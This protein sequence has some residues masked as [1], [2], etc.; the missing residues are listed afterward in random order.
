M[1]LCVQMLIP[2]I[3]LFLSL[4]CSVFHG[5][6]PGH[7]NG[8]GIVDSSGKLHFVF[9]NYFRDNIIHIERDGNRWKQEDVVSLSG[10]GINSEMFNLDGFLCVDTDS[11]SGL[12]R[13]CL[14]AD[15]TWKV[16]RE[17]TV[18]ID[19]YPYCHWSSIG[20]PNDI[21]PDGKTIAGCTQTLQ[22][23]LPVYDFFLIDN[24]A[25]E[26]LPHF[27][28]LDMQVFDSMSS[29]PVNYARQPW[30]RE[31]PF[32]NNEQWDAASYIV[33]VAYWD[34][35]DESTG[36]TYLYYVYFD[37]TGWHFE[38]IHER[39]DNWLL[40]S[41]PGQIWGYGLETIVFQGKKVTMVSR[42][43]I[44][45]KDT[46]TGKV[47]VEPLDEKYIATYKAA[48]AARYNG[49]KLDLLA[50]VVTSDGKLHTLMEDMDEDETVLYYYMYN[51]DSPTP[52]VPETIEWLDSVGRR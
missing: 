11:G 41:W 15:G 3:M 31:S 19:R 48:T 5:N 34:G 2:A 43:A 4:G 25:G 37:E 29:P 32:Y 45:K 6:Q 39:N 7:Y 50:D 28:A 17:K 13:G 9:S 24:I 1:K 44:V 49:R 23:A 20:R 42:Q 36:T 35:E 33:G 52:E 22:D 27:A 21:T 47:I 8:A 12:F 14:S 18:T 40:T 16:E 38:K 51:P 10:T 26:V 30:L 46:D